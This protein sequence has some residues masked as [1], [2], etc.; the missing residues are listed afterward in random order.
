MTLICRIQGCTNTGT[1]ESQRLEPPAS[2]H[3]RDN[4]NNLK[5]SIKW[6]VAAPAYRAAAAATT[7][8]ALIAAT[9]APHKWK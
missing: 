9:G 7:V 4:M 8:A 2:R 6:R 3:E 1:A 5:S